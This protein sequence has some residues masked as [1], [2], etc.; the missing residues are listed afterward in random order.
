V[1]TI[2][3]RCN[4][5]HAVGVSCGTVARAR[6]E[7]NQ[8]VEHHRQHCKGCPNPRRHL[9]NLERLDDPKKWRNRPIGARAGS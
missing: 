9:M 2:C 5:W 6:R 3:H 4:M 8:K 1:A 7:F